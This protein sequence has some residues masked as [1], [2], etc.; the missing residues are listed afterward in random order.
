MSLKEAFFL[1]LK[2]FCTVTKIKELQ[3]I[4]FVIYQFLY[5]YF[6]F[7]MSEKNV[8]NLLPYMTKQNIRHF[9]I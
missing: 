6:V 2:T 1:Y 8:F 3:L 5:F 4:V 9:V 7:I